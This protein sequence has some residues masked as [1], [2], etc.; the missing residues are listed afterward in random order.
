MASRTA[1]SWLRALG[2]TLRADVDVLNNTNLHTENLFGLWVA[3]D[4]S[5]PTH[6]SPF[7]LQGGL[8][9]PDRDYY[10]N[11]VAAHGRD[12]H[13][14]PG[15]HR[16]ACCSWH[17]V[18]DAHGGCREVFALEQ[19]IA[20]V[21]VSRGDSEDVLKGNNHW[22]PATSQAAPRDST[23]AHSSAPRGWAPRHEFVV[24]QPARAHRASQP[25]WAASRWRPGRNTCASTTSSASSPYLP[26]A[27]AD[28]HFDFHERTLSGTP[29]QRRA[30]SVP[31]QE[32]N[33]ALGEAVGQLYVAK[34]FPASEKA[35]AEAM[36]EEPAGRVR[37]SASTS[38]SGW[39]RQTRAE[40]KAKLAALKVGVG[41]P[42]HWRDYAGLEVER[43]DAF[44]NAERAAAV[45]IPAQSCQARPAGRSRRV[46]HEPAA[47][48]RG[49]PA[50][51]ERAQLP[52]RDPAAAV[53]RSEPRSVAMDYGGTGGTSSG[54]RSATASTTR[55]HCSTRTGGCATGG[56][57]RT[58]RTSRRPARS[59]RPSSTPTSPSRTYRVNGKQTL[60]ENIADVAGLSAAYDAVAACRRQRRRGASRRRLH[61]S[62]SSSSSASRRAGGP[63]YASR[64]AAAH[65]HRRPRAGRVPRRHR[66][67]PRPVVR[68]LQ[69]AARRRSSTLRRR[70]GSASGRQAS[71]IQ[72]LRGTCPGARGGAGPSGQAETSR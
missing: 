71:P 72:R 53:L 25:W 66:A 9:M 52:R 49:E 69:R 10:L 40:A 56:P 29:Q 31:S 21:H 37:R 48:E 11:P 58:S 14:V 8:V 17:G 54:T 23:G 61:R 27:F 28:E 18:A 65:R 55:A 70:R 7:L 50:G 19:R 15:A 5:D 33:A 20:A 62:S 24:W 4:L 16:S 36:V 59:W 41:Y 68:R 6:Y 39:R 67:Q 64:R 46:G 35:R 42:D 47:G 57:S 43:G 51:D 3:Q 32:T 22:S 1:P 12:P 30:G 60:S 26:K 44:G 45:R 13:P 63:R 34:Y 2:A 38:W